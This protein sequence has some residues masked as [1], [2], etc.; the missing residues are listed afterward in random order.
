[1]VHLASNKS[2]FDDIIKDIDTF[3][4]DCDGVLWHG[5]TAIEGA[6][7]VVNKLKSMGKRVY[8]VSNN[9]TKTRDES[10]EKFKR[11][12][13]SQVAREEVFGPAY[14]SALWLKQNISPEGKV[15][16]IGNEA[17]EQEL[18]ACGIKYLGF[19]PD[20]QVTEQSARST[21]K[22]TLEDNVEAVLVG[23]DGHFSFTK[24]VKSASYLLDPKCKFVVTNED[25]RFPFPG[26]KHVLIGTGA[27][28]AAVKTASAREPDVVCGK[29][30]S[31]MFQCFSNEVELDVSKCLMVGDN[32][33]TDILFGIRNGMKTML[34]MGGV[35]PKSELDEKCADIKEKG[36]LPMYY[37]DGLH[38][39]MEFFN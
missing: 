37:M 33:K 24:L 10:F 25:D 26:T 22:A 9:N 2:V 35:T 13:F 36:K 38:S 8:F 3:V 28:S 32:L 1:M 4:F 12:G 6:V 21:L 15:Y 29:P 34:V 23:A 11:L 7:F 17:M 27:L 30:H 16:V 14:T 20:S 5:E 19:G 18:K 39:W 31:F